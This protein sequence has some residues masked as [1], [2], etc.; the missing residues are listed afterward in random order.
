MP[1]AE[2]MIPTLTPWKLKIP[3][4]CFRCGK[5]FGTGAKAYHLNNYGLL[6]R[7]CA[8]RWAAI[9]NPA[10]MKQEKSNA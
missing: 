3:G 4:E 8:A 1:G 2:G 6:C 5:R 9:Y 7:P 10:A